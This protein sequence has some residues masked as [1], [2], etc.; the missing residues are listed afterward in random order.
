MMK[1][2]GS[3]NEETGWGSGVLGGLLKREQRLT[4]QREMSGEFYFTVLCQV[5]D[6]GRIR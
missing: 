5:P 6:A 2:S 4:R 1:M 3:W